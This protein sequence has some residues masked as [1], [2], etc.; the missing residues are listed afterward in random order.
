M[1]L[2]FK[3]AE[4]LFWKYQPSELKNLKGYSVHSREIVEQQISKV[5]VV[6]DL[7]ILSLLWKIELNTDRRLLP[8][9]SLH[10]NTEYYF[11]TESSI[12]PEAS[13]MIIEHSIKILK[14]TFNI[15]KVSTDFMNYSL[16]IYIQKET[17][18]DQLLNCLRTVSNLFFK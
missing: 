10:L 18:A 3:N 17:L 16:P 2:S 13:L 4:V 5:T 6:D 1:K 7:F 11:S 15:K 14:N 12:E 9:L 8:Q